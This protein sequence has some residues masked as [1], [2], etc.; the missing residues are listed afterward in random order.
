MLG[1]L[2]VE[3]GLRN[4]GGVF[5]DDFMVPD[6]DRGWSLRPGFGGWVSAENTL[7]MRINSDGLRDREHPLVHPAG[8][9]RVAVLGDSYMQ[10]LNVPVEKTFPS[11]LEGR[12]TDCLAA[13]GTTAETLN[14]GVSGYGTAQELLTFR[15]HAAKYRPDI[16]VLAFYTNNDVFNNSRRL[17]PAS[18]P[19]QSPYFVFDG[20]RLVSDDAFRAVLEANARQ[21]WWRRVR[22]TITQ[23]LRT[24][25]LLYETW[26]AIRPYVVTTPALPAG[27]GQDPR[28]T[29]NL[30]DQIYRAP[31]V[32]AI[33]EA[34]RVTD[35]L[36]LQL[37]QEV[38]A[39]G[40]E[41]W[42]VTLANAP[43]IDPDPAARTALESRLGV[44]SLF[45][46]DEHVR[47]FAEG[48]GIPVVM[49]APAM[50]DYALLHKAYLNGGYSAQTP[51][52]SGHWNEVGNRV[53]AELVGARLCEASGAI[54]AVRKLHTRP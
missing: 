16:V 14:F 38:A 50:A 19:E 44:D 3:A 17:N 53:A 1:L 39:Q 11:F 25:Q 45:A 18:N 28:E 4:I 51:F 22:I 6:P 31:V 2:V 34:W 15:H 29:D 42:I 33:V 8:T 47:N 12:M 23:R 27:T 32:P 36:L 46:P 7:W 52:G 48:H 54:L 37:K 49:L 40:A 43:Q 10:G 41:L 26:G 5:Q 35:A 21:P 24:A 9:V 30:E 13:T 20:D